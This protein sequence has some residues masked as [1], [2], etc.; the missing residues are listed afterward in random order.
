[1]RKV[2]LLMVAYRELR[3][4][5]YC[6]SDYGKYV[7]LGLRIM[8]K[9]D[10]EIVVSAET[11]DYM[12]TGKS[13]RLTTAQRNGIADG[14]KELEGCNLIKIKETFGKNFVVLTNGLKIDEND[15]GKKDLYFQV[16]IEFVNK[17]ASQKNG[18]KLVNYY[19]LLLSS[20]NIKSKVSFNGME[21]F[22]EFD[23][24][25]RKA[26]YERNNKLLELGV[27]EII[28][29]EKSRDLE[30][31]LVATSNTYAQVGDK[32]LAMQKSEEILSKK[33]SDANKEIKKNRK[34]EIR[35]VESSGEKVNMPKVE[36]TNPEIPF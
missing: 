28:S 29:S 8:Y 23:G 24:V 15:S 32:S 13:R 18:L 22:Q 33:V 26:M 3:N 25:S 19:L 9:E 7:Y 35:Q 4:E 30:G 17:V 36:Y 21:Y 2:S 16:P 6:L 20:I 1:M 27:I 10:T 31:K 14:L 34:T 12:I 5:Y 11:L